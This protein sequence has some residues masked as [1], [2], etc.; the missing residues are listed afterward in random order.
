MGNVGSDPPDQ[1][2]RNMWA[3]EDHDDVEVAIIVYTETLKCASSLSQEKD[4]QDNE[5]GGGTTVDEESRI[6]AKDGEL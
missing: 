2:D 5:A 4:G 3:H 1:I 6:V